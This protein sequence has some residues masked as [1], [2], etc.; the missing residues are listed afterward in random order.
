MLFLNLRLSARELTVR[1]GDHNIDDYKD[2]YWSTA[3]TYRHVVTG[4]QLEH[5][6]M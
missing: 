3:R 5:T 4:A 1:L 2:D 6:G